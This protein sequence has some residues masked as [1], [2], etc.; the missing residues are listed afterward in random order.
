MLDYLAPLISLVFLRIS[1][2]RRATL[3]RAAQARPEAVAR[4][5]CSV[6][7]EAA[8]EALRLRGMRPGM[9][10]ALFRLVPRCLGAAEV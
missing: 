8:D 2:P 9:R 3:P 1:A 5:R 6:V 10:D 7:G 4:R